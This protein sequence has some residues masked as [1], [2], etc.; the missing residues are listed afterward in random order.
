[1]VVPVYNGADT[2]RELIVR[3]TAVLPSLFSEYEIIL[4]NDGSPDQSWQVT[5][6]LI[7]EFP[8]IKGINLMRN[9]GQ[10]NALLCGIRAARMEYVLTLDDDLQEP[11]EEI[12]K[13]VEK[14][15]PDYDVVYGIPVKLPHSGWRN[16]FSKFTKRVIANVMGIP[17]IRN[18]STFRLFKTDL[19][20]AFETYASPNVMIDA[21]LSWGTSRFGTTPVNEM[22]RE[23]GNSNYDFYKLMSMAFLVMTNFSTVPLRF[24]SLMGFGITLFGLVILVYVVVMALI[25]GSV[26]GFPFLASIITIFSG[27]QLLTLGIFGEYLGSIFT[28]STERQP[29][30]IRD[31]VE[32]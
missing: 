16:F 9:N 25:E 17:N 1:V 15:S 23:V 6:E 32:K 24:A 30:V 12:H 5:Q 19:R 2:L 13:L 18:I 26:P 3:L 31:I 21:L 28:R 22:P 7:D 4:V 27:T 20:K 10:H 8:S 14:M 29:Y 11:P